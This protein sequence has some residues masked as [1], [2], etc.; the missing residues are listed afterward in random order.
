MVPPSWAKADISVTAASGRPAPRIIAPDPNNIQQNETLIAQVGLAEGE[1]PGD[2][3][4]QWKRSINTTDLNDEDNWESINNLGDTPYEY[5]LTQADVGNHIKVTVTKDGVSIDSYYTTQVVNVNDLPTGQV[6]INKDLGNTVGPVN[7]YSLY[8]VLIANADSLSNDEKTEI[9]TY[10]YQWQ[11]SSDSVDWENIDNPSSSPHEYTLTHADVDKYIRVTV[12]YTDKLGSPQQILINNIGLDVNYDI[13]FQPKK[14]DVLI[15]NTDSLSD[16]DGKIL[17]SFTYQWQRSTDLTDEDNWDDITGATDSKYTLTQEDVYKYIRVAVSYTDN[18][19]TTH[20]YRDTDS[21]PPALISNHNTFSVIAFNFNPTGNV[22]INGYNY[23]NNILTADTTGL[24]DKDGINYATFTYQWQRSTD[25]TDE[26]NWEN[27]DNLGDTPSEYLLTEADENNYIRVAVEYTDNEK[28]IHTYRDTDSPPPALISDPTSKISYIPDGKYLDPASNSIVSCPDNTYSRQGAIG[29]EECKST[30][31]I[32]GGSYIE[33]R[34]IKPCPRDRPYSRQGAKSDGECKAESDIPDGSYLDGNTIKPCRSNKPYT[35]EGRTDYGSSSCKTFNNDDRALYKVID[36]DNKKIKPCP[37]GIIYKS[38]EVTSPL[39]PMPEMTMTEEVARRE[40]KTLEYNIEKDRTDAFQEAKRARAREIAREQ[41]KNKEHDRCVNQF[42]NQGGTVNNGTEIERCP[43][44]SPYSA[45]G[46]TEQ[47]KCFKWTDNNT[48]ILNDPIPPGVREVTYQWQRSS[49]SESWEEIEGATVN[50]YL[51]TEADVDNHIRVEVTYHYIILGNNTVYESK[52]TQTIVDSRTLTPLTINN[53]INEKVSISGTLK[54]GYVLKAN[55]NVTVEYQWQRSS[56]SDNWEDITDAETSTYTLTEADVDNYIRVAVS[57]YY[58]NKKFENTVYKSNFTPTIVDSRTLTPLTIQHDINEKVSINGTLQKGS[59]LNAV[60]YDADPKIDNYSLKNCPED[61]VTFLNNET[62]KEPRSLS[63][64]QNIDENHIVTGYFTDD[65]ISSGNAYQLAR[66][67]EIE[68][69]HINNVLVKTPDDVNDAAPAGWYRYVHTSDDDSSDSYYDIRC[70]PERPVSK[71][72]ATSIDECGIATWTDDYGPKPCPVATP[73]STKGNNNTSDQCFADTPGKWIQI[74]SSSGSSVEQNCGSVGDTFYTPK[75][76]ATSES[77]CFTEIPSGFYIEHENSTTILPCPTDKPY[78]REG[79]ITSSECKA[80]SDI[81]DGSYIEDRTIKDCSELQGDTPYTEE[82]RDNYDINSCKGLGDIKS[83]YYVQDGK[84]IRLCTQLRP[85]QYTYTTA[86]RDGL[87]PGDRVESEFNSSSCK[88]ASTVPDGYYIGETG[89]DIYGIFKCDGETP[90]TEEGR[91]KYNINSCKGLGDIE[92][93]KYLTPANKN[94]IQIIR[95]CGPNTYTEEG[96]DNYNISSC[97]G[98]NTI[99]TGKYLDGNTIKRCPFNKPYTMKNRREKTRLSDFGED[100]CKGVNDIINNTYLTRDN[101]I[102][103]CNNHPETMGNQ[104]SG[105][106]SKM[107]RS[108]EYDNC[109]KWI[110]HTYIEKTEKTAPDGGIISEHKR[111]NCPL[112]KTTEKPSHMAFI[113]GKSGVND[114]ATDDDEIPMDVSDC[115]FAKAPE[116]GTY[117]DN[118]HYDSDCAG[119]TECGR[120]T[121]WNEFHTVYTNP[122]D[123]EDPKYNWLHYKES[124]RSAY[125]HHDRKCCR[126]TQSVMGGFGLGILGGSWCDETREP[127]QSCHKDNECRTT[128]DGKGGSCSSRWGGYD[129]IAEKS[130]SKF[131]S[132]FCTG[133]GEAGDWC[134]DIDHCKD[135]HQCGYRTVQKNDKHVSHDDIKTAAR[136]SR[137]DASKHKIPSYMMDLPEDQRGQHHGATAFGQTLKLNGED[138]KT[139]CGN[140]SSNQR[141]EGV[142]FR[143]QQLNCEASCSIPSADESGYA[144]AVAAAG[145]PG[146]PAWCDRLTEGARQNGGWKVAGFPTQCGWVGD[147]NTLPILKYNTKEE[148]EAQHGNNIVSEA[149]LRIDKMDRGIYDMATNAYKHNSAADTSAALVQEQRDASTAASVLAYKKIRDDFKPK[150]T[151][152]GGLGREQWCDSYVMPGG[153]CHYDNECMFDGFC[154]YEDGADKGRCYQ[155]CDGENA[156]TTGFGVKDGHWCKKPRSVGGKKFGDICEDHSDCPGETEC[157]WSTRWGPNGGYTKRY[158]N[159]KVTDH[160]KCCS[161]K[162]SGVFRDW[163]DSMLDKGERCNYSN[164]CKTGNCGRDFGY[165]CDFWNGLGG[166]CYKYPYNQCF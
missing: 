129:H 45:K 7:E 92:N 60:T 147:N 13:S 142:W 105:G 48:Y 86:E 96:R 17:A 29:S 52:S 121:E 166:L 28:T 104:T 12:K 68:L 64:C 144:A 20:T 4:Y 102:D 36:N 159:G 84:T 54:E 111:K 63:D 134:N 3:T 67:S 137:D 74:D 11:R 35:E 133:G 93:N 128:P 112:G 38:Y 140:P 82:G 53:D 126:S 79:A 19:G 95:N 65:D 157:G 16:E 91:D 30:S 49:D 94:G 22:T 15:A 90:Y 59:A 39:Y 154:Y 165:H 100:S 62:G 85:R 108:I 161:G 98:V 151:S 130:Q 160:Q 37:N 25:L 143:W 51:L 109:I 80:E 107:D 122:D 97:K 88:D 66:V 158:I 124:D 81:P 89:D 23:V 116:Q 136:F 113:D 31:N 42:D 44:D 5:T 87:A 103:S 14:Y 123:P 73:Y 138:K 41:R 162:T 106:F 9:T 21:P 50:E 101:E 26:D 163:C 141:N 125:A 56:D 135:G 47:A 72:G 149:A 33:D 8:N 76:G 115:A 1:D 146:N 153:F 164:E 6:T 145:G 43:E 114:A 27:I 70:P 46:E 69:D 40:G 152:S 110:P 117:G 78:C 10:T 120:S 99:E 58:S 150:T 2:F 24:V 61:M 148:A 155:S 131:E 34:T 18:E 55:R 57:Y 32:E 156:M 127:S 71:S 118:C 119:G 139:C 132:D 83:G 77:E 75:G